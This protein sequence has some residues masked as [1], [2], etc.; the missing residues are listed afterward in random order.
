MAGIALIGVP[1]RELALF[2]VVQAV[3]TALLG[4]VLSFC[5]YVLAGEIAAKMFGQGLPEGSALA[6]ITAAQ[7]LAICFGVLV[8]VI[9]AAALAGWSAARLDPAS[10]LR[11]A[12]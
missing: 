12:G 6:V 1:G 7:A 8:L 11:E 4:L 2:P 5:F 9:V 10:V 3:I